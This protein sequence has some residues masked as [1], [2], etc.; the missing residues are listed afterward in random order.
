MWGR[1][2]PTYRAMHGGPQDRPRCQV[3]NTWVLQNGRCYCA[4]LILT[5]H[6]LCLEDGEACERVDI[7]LIAYAVRR[8]MVLRG[9]TNEALYPISIFL[10]TFEHMALGFSDEA[11]AVTVMEQMKQAAHKGTWN[12]IDLSERIEQYYAFHQD[13]P[14]QE[15]WNLYQTAAEFKRQGVGAT[16]KA[17]RFSLV[18]ANYEVGVT[19]LTTVDTHLSQHPRCSCQH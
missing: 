18:N 15:G 13:S 7:P 11:K 8:P 12:L 10:E 2:P 19:P 9:D 17:W 14:S 6:H 3:A 4:S 16:T 5:D 1:L